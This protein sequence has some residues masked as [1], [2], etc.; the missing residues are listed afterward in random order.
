M[1][2][3]V[4]GIDIGGT[5]TKFGVVD[6]NGNCLKDNFTSTDKFVDFEVYLEH[7]HTEIVELISTI[8]EEIKIRGIGIGA[9][10]GNYYQGTI[11]MAPNLNW[12]GIIPFVEKFQ[13]YFPGIPIRLTNDANA[14]AIGEMIYGVQLV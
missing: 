10:N 4:I 5:F 3:V 9:P 6:R 2:E 13:D 1:K 7:L 8:N 12:K 11:E 14:A